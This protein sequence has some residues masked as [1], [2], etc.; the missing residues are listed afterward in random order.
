M[1]IIADRL[2]EKVDQPSYLCGFSFGGYVVL[3]MYRKAPELVKGLILMGSTTEADTTAQ[4]EG[5]KNSIGR[6]R[7]GEY[8]DMVEA[9]ASLTFSPAGLEDTQLMEKRKKIVRDYGPERFISHV[10]AAMHRQD[11]TELLSHA[12]LPVLIVAGGED[13]L[14]SP[15]RLKELAGRI[16]G[17][18][19][20][21]IE[22]TGHMMPM[23]Q[24]QQIVQVLGQWIQ[25]QE[26]KKG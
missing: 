24:P 18:D 16:P 5:R 26:G 15:E 7:R 4:F 13:R 9:N 11:Y 20:E 6:A 8:F 1:G 22:K 10:T 21:I 19:F 23:E 14:F 17:A 25:N 12:N 2:L 3:E